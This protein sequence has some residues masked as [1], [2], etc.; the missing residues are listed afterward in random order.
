MLTEI[1][2]PFVEDGPA[3][4]WL[5]NNIDLFRVEVID[6][7]VHE[8]YHRVYISVVFYDEAEAVMF[9]LRFGNYE[10]NRNI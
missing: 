2:I 4:K 6:F 1:K 7:F 9:K 8:L 3:I 10:D 5:E